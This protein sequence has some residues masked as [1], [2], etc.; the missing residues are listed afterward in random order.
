MGETVVNTDASQRPA[1]TA[2]ALP[3]ELPPAECAGEE[4][5]RG[6]MTGPWTEWRFSDPM[7]NSSQLVFPRMS[8]PAVRKRRTT[9]AS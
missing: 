7:P 3:P 4:A 2:A 8:A 1:A 9:V 5:K 6:L